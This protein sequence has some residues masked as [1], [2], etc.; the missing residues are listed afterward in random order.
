M[1]DCFMLFSGESANQRLYSSNDGLPSTQ[2]GVVSSAQSGKVRQL[3]LGK[4]NL[5][6]GGEGSNNM[7]FI[8]SLVDSTGPVEITGNIAQSAEFKREGI[9]LGGGGGGIHDFATTALG[10]RRALVEREALPHIQPSRCWATEKDFR[11]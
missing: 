11:S 6:L 8:V 7:N 3:V 5:F 1:Y 2:V 10:A 4:H 9:T